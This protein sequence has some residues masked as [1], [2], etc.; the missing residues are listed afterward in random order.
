MKT[1]S[2]FK[3]FFA[4]ALFFFSA[5]SLMAQSPSIATISNYTSSSINVTVYTA[6]NCSTSPTPA[7]ST[8][9]SV[10][11][12]TINGIY[13]MTC[14]DPIVSMFVQ[15]GASG[16]TLDT[17][18]CSC[19]PGTATTPSGSFGGVNAS[20]YCTSGLGSNDITTDIW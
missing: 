8:T 5:S 14:S 19:L 17:P 3:G 9:V 15:V 7:C 13:P 1:L 18:G 2:L 16:I 6:S 4:F 20:S 12:G 10:P 11:G